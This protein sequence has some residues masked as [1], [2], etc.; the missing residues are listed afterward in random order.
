MSSRRSYVAQH[1]HG[2]PGLFHV[3]VLMQTWPPL[4]PLRRRVW[5]RRSVPSAIAPAVA[6]LP[7]PVTKPVAGVLSSRA[8]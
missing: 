6:V 5:F 1:R 2:R 8:A 4:R 3:A 7:V